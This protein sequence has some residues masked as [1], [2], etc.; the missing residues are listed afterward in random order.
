MYTY[1]NL[2]GSLQSMSIYAFFLF[3]SGQAAAIL[4]PHDPMRRSISKG[5][6]K[7]EWQLWLL[8]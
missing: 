3:L 2:F 8:K 5:D 4:W 6:Q 7:R 1:L